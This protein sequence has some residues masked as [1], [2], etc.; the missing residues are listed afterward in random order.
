MVPNQ[1]II[2]LRRDPKVHFTRT[3]ADPL[4]KSAAEAYGDKVIG[5]VLSGGNS[6]GANGLLSIKAHGGRAIVQDPDEAPV[7]DM[8]KAAIA[9]D[10]PDRLT[11]HCIAEFLAEQAPRLVS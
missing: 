3:A 10:N 1:F 8:P 7:P 11:A 6:D 2:W 5:I 9:A 4:F